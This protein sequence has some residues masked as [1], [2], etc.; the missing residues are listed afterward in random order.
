LINGRTQIFFVHFSGCP[1]DSV[2]LSWPGD[3]GYASRL[4]RPSPG[5]AADKRRPC[6][7]GQQDGPRRLGTAQ[8]RTDPGTDAGIPARTIRYYEGIGLLRSAD[9]AA[10]GYRVYDDDVQ[11][12]RFVQ[13]ARGLG[14]PVE[15]VVNLL[16]LWR[17]ETPT[18]AEV[19][20]LALNRIGDIDRKIQELDSLKQAL[21][22]LSERC[23]GDDRPES[24]ILEELSRPGDGE[25]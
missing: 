6:C 18:S 22:N 20:S 11:T 3:A 2:K 1:L 14:F 13:R 5:A 12:L 19:K 15:D 23:H 25:N 4:D 21:V 24:P 9:R 16:E 7:H 8:V 10:N 17:D